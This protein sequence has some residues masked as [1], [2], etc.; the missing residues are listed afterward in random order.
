[1]RKIGVKCLLISAA[2]TMFYSCQKEENLDR[3]SIQKKTDDPE[4]TVFE[5]S[6]F[7]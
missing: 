1:M 3:P 4:A 7:K 2:F 6:F 5:D